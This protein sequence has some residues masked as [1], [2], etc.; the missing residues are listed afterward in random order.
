MSKTRL[1]IDPNDPQGLSRGRVDHKVLDA[2]SEADIARHTRDDDAEA[3]RDMG[4]F[5]R[6]VRR[7]LGLTQV[8]FAR[9]IDVPHET[10]RNWEQGKPGP[11]GAARALLKILDKAP[12]T[13]LRV[14]G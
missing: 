13:A 10:I 1:T 14:L 12:E 5:A 11:T 3:M 4:R 6:R 8:E 2:T 9:R 7:R